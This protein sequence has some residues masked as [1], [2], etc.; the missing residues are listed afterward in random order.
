MSSIPARLGIQQRVLPAYRLGLFDAL[1]AAAERGVGVFAGQ[2]RPAEAIECSAGLKIA[3]YFPAHNRHFFKSSFYLCWQSG[4]VDWLEE[5]QPDVLVAE[6]NPRYLSTRRALR[7]MH[8]RGK[9]VIGWGLGAPQ[10]P[11]VMGLL[12]GLMR[13]RFIRPFDALIT[14]SQKG[15]AEYRSLGFDAQRIFVAPNAVTPRPTHPPPERPAAFGEAPIVLFVGRLQERKRI[16]LLLQACARLPQSCQPRLWVVGEGPARAELEA[17]AARVYP[18]AQ[19]LG[20]RYGADLETYFRQ[21]DLFVLPGT[22]GLAV[23][24]AMSYALPVM[25]AE[26]DGTQADLVRP[27]NGWQLPPGSLDALTAALQEAFQDVARLR[28]MGEASYRIVAEEINL[29][30]MVNVFEHAV[31]S[32]WRD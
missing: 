20:G 9:P 28:R 11:G 25:A 17:Q 18:A 10:S 24:Q 27:E 22:G 6:A 15:A 14:Y 19:F 2:A 7:S 21:A 4:L 16:D 23:Q 1:A 30:N 31:R 26:A 32:V 3:A 29:E 5:W 8:A 12:Q 13:R